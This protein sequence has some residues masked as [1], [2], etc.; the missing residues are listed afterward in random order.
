MTTTSTDI[1]E[2]DWAQLGILLGCEPSRKTP[3]LERLLLATARRCP[4]N[5][6]LLPIAVTWLVEY[7]GFV[8]RHRL[9]RLAQDELAPDDQAALGLIIDEAVA[10]GATR[11][12]LIVAE[13]CRP[14]ERP[15][16]L[17]TLQ[18]DSAA[19]AR[20]AEKHA[21]DASRRWG[22]WAPPV[23]LKRD[24]LRPVSW[25]LSRNSGYRD[26]IVRK[27]DLRVSILE[28]LRRDVPGGIAPSESALTRL[29]GAT[30]TA[31]RKALAALALEGEVT[32]GAASGRDH[33]VSLRTAA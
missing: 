12:L 27:G 4:D 13:V 14:Q 32:V 10:N 30:R 29:S 33:A 1:I 17:S 31:V 11:D 7:G 26:R 16:P 24:A 21:S 20:I 25:L 23:T 28:T 19:L 22:V 5:A 8:A 6:R 15:S 18:R 3:D 9:K 2:R